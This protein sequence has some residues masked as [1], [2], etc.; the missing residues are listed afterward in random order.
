MRLWKSICSKWSQRKEPVQVKEPTQLNWFTRDP[1]QID[2]GAVMKEEFSSFL[3]GDRFQRQSDKFCLPQ[4]PAHGELPISSTTTIFCLDVL[5]AL[6]DNYWRARLILYETARK[7]SPLASILGLI[8]LKLD[9]AWVPLDRALAALGVGISMSEWVT[10]TSLELYYC[11]PAIT[12]NDSSF[13]RL[14]KKHKQMILADLEVSN[15][16]EFS[17][18]E[19]KASF[20]R[21]DQEFRQTVIGPLKDGMINSKSVD[22]QALEEKASS[23]NKQVVAYL[24]KLKSGIEGRQIDI[25]R[26]ALKTKYGTPPLPGYIW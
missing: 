7:D 11:Y 6:R 4:Y 15:M 20:L 14:L 2:E 17:L 25:V 12:Q 22:C 1:P 16:I 26:T 13:D 18:A 23:I 8:T 21:L 5:T 10:H 24:E 19:A 3:D 9:P